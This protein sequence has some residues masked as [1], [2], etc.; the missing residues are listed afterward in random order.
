VVR[1]SGTRA[2]TEKVT[3]HLAMADKFTYDDGGGN[4]RRGLS[5]PAHGEREP[6]FTIYSKRSKAFAF[7]HAL[8]SQQFLSLFLYFEAFSG[9]NCGITK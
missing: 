1:K 9:K 6:I 8:F 7:A 2:T 3:R 4:L 5:D